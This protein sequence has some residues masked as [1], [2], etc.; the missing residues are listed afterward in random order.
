MSETVGDYLLH[1]LTTWG[2]KRR[3]LSTAAAPVP[4]PL[5]QDRLSGPLPQ[6]A[7]AAILERSAQVDRTR[8][9]GNGGRREIGG[10]LLH[11]TREPIPRP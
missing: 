6:I 10:E 7:G 11:R 3:L 4:C 9:R 8:V 1:R 5:T 2:V